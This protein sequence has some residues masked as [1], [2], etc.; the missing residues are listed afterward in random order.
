MQGY[1]KLEKTVHARPQLISNYFKD[2]RTR[3]LYSNTTIG[4]ETL[5][6][7]KTFT[8]IKGIGL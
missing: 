2:N 4:M 6:Q 8:I 1:I 5:H 7:R 3:D